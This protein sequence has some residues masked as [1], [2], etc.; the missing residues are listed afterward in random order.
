M[1]FINKVKRAIWPETRALDQY[2]K[3][4]KSGQGTILGFLG[5]RREVQE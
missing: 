2:Q 1:P 5:I 4:Q 3:Y